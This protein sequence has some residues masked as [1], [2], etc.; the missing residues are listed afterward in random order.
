MNNNMPNVPPASG[1]SYSQTEGLVCEECGS[2]VFQ[3]GFLLRKVSALVSPTGKETV[4]PV[5]VFACLSCNHVNKDMYPV[6]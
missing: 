3:P 1:L 5:Q 4:V 2:T 6:E